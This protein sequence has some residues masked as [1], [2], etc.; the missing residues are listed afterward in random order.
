MEGRLSDN[1]VELGLMNAHL[2][3]ERRGF[4]QK[5]G[6][7]SRVRTEWKRSVRLMS[8][9]EVMNELTKQQWGKIASQWA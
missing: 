8:K 7:S 6:Q 5:L 1:V 3:I 2:E 9:P 4:V